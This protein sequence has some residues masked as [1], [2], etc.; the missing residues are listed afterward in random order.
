MFKKFIAVFLSASIMMSSMGG[1]FAA[2][3]EILINE[4][5][6]DYSTNYL[7]SNATINGTEARV[8]E[9]EEN[10]N[11]ALFARTAGDKVEFSMPL[12]STDTQMVYAFDVKIEGDFVKG[13]AFAC[14]T[15]K[16][17][18]TFAENGAVLLE[19]QYQVGSYGDK[20]WHS[21]VAQVDFTNKIYNVYVDGKLKVEGRRFNTA[22][23]VQ[24]VAKIAFESLSVD[25]DSKILLDNI[26]V[27]K[28]NT[29]LSEADFPKK[30]YNSEVVEYVFESESVN[31]DGI[32]LNTNSYF[33]WAH[34]SMSMD[35]TNHTG[36]TYLPGEE[37]F[38]YYRYK[39]HPEALPVYGTMPV[40][41]DNTKEFVYEIEVYPKLGEV[42]AN[43]GFF[44][45]DSDNNAYCRLLRLEKD[46][47]LFSGN[48]QVS[49]IAMNKW[50]H[51][52]I[53]CNL[54]DGT[55]D[56][57]VNREFIRSVDLEKGGFVPDKIRIG[58]DKPVVGAK[59]EFYVNRLKI[60]KGL[61]L[62][63]FED[64]SYNT[65]PREFPSLN[66]SAEEVKSIIGS[67]A[68]FMTTQNTYFCEGE[69]QEYDGEYD[70]YVTENEIVM[71][72]APL[73][74]KAFGIDIS[75]KRPLI[76]VN[77][78]TMEIGSEKI[79]DGGELEE[80]PIEKDGI[81]YLPIASFAEKVLSKYAYR[82]IRNFVLVSDENREYTNAKAEIENDETVDIIY[83][84]LQFERP[85]GEQ[86]MADAK[87]MVA[88]KKTYPS[89]LFDNEKI[90]DFKRKIES[91]AALESAFDN[92]L[93][94]CESYMLGTYV[95]PE[96]LTL[97]AYTDQLSGAGHYY[98]CNRIRERVQYLATAYYG[99]GDKKY[100]DRMWEEIKYVLEWP[101]WQ[102]QRFLY[103]AVAFTAS[104]WAYSVLH[105][106]LTVEERQYFR[107]MVFD[108]CLDEYMG[109]YTGACS[110][111]VKLFKN[112]QTN[113][114]AVVTAGPLIAVLSFLPDLEEGS[115]EA[116]KCTYFIENAI[117]SLEYPI[118]RFYPDGFS[119]EGIEYWK[120]YVENISCCIYALRQMCGT[121]YSISQ[122]PGFLKSDN[123]ILYM[124]SPVG[125]YNYANYTDSLLKQLPS[126]ALMVAGFAEDD[127][128]MQ[129]VNIY[130]KILGIDATAGDLLWYEPSKAVE[131]IEM[132]LDYLFEKYQHASMRSAWDD[133]YCTY[134]GIAGGTFEGDSHA[135]KGAFVFD[136][137]GIRWIWDLGKGN[138][139]VE[140]GYYYDD[141]L[142]LYRKKAEG[143]NV[144]VINPDKVS[145]GQTLNGYSEF[146]RFES[147]DKGTIGVLDLKDVYLGQVES[148]IRG[149]Y[150]GEDRNSLIVQDELVL[151]KAENDIYSFMHTKADIEIAEDGKSAILSQDGK[152]LLIEAYS[153]AKEWHL[154][155]QEAAYIFPEMQRKNEYDRSMYK[156][157]ALV[158]KASGKLNISFK[159]RMLDDGMNYAAHSFV[160]ISEWEIPDGELAKG[161]E[162]SG[163]Y[164]NNKVLPDFSPSKRD[165][166]VTLEATGEMPKVEAY[167]DNA[168]ISIEVDKDLGEYAVI[169]AT[170]PNGRKM[171]VNVTIKYDIHLKDREGGLFKALP[172]AGLPGGVALADVR[173]VIASENDGNIPE[174]AIDGKLD[175]RWSAASDGAYMEVDLGEV[176]DLS[177][178]AVGVAYG[179][180]RQNIFEIYISNDRVNYTRIYDGISLGTT[181]KLEYIPMEVSA[182]F[183]RY[184]GHGNTSNYWNSVSEFRPCIKK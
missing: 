144:L 142:T 78:K 135:E 61:A 107:Q 25:D 9:T 28:G 14:S 16:S 52:A 23:Q 155:A 88:S 17:L 24:K 132:P 129:T 104:G 79:S 166:T 149:F 112:R 20:K 164:I 124:Q 63:S 81:L 32:Y 100:L 133:E 152:R 73:I 86:V 108:Q 128:L 138:Y 69:K 37:P 165:Y 92:V 5:F 67:D 184:V 158:G 175:T 145:A 18:F 178:V 168:E 96:E 134:V 4:V 29:V 42:G 156:K 95:L 8:V 43:L 10:K 161:P 40:E 174:G 105:D 76:S 93:K 131:G 71:V 44:L 182:R 34:V 130:K 140:G 122:A 117:Q 39:N 64:V 21:Y 119:G 56:V 170:A 127:A 59:D 180:T 30:D 103:T 70:A 110:Y 157:V 151:A 84:F 7:P 102:P 177:G 139:E 160:P 45:S 116:A 183:V 154:E 90:E 114:G 123:E 83:R 159:L 172:T 115:D 167:S 126:E 99:T 85:S 98:A 60:Y 3:N 2:D 113:W 38:K 141:G 31:T 179:D 147:K 169:T 54:T 49:K 48:T 101:T 12:S 97:S 137:E 75:F 36:A 94:K 125:A 89:L 47:N 46:G 176:K 111:D 11:K 1:V 57:Y 153:D 146:T 109:I 162:L 15:G 136:K 77:D 150:L 80:A 51:I 171:V 120:Y 87:K 91:D 35:D 72:S 68:V 66:D 50:T 13:S 58:I 26:R 118:G 82:D 106:H 163:L 19:D 55:G 143:N 27:Y 41:I 121:D 22:P 173:S 74:A 65:D 181:T 33:G 6:N 148:Y 62:R 53:A